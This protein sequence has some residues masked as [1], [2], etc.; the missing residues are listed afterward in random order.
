MESRPMLSRSML[1]LPSRQLLLLVLS[2]ER[3]IDE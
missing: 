2:S 1:E 3:E